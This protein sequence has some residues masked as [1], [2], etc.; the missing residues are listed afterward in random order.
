NSDLG[1]GKIGNIS[2]ETERYI[3]MLVENEGL[4]FD[5]TKNKTSVFS[6]L[7]S[8][9]EGITSENQND[10]NGKDIAEYHCQYEYEKMEEVTQQIEDGR[11]TKPCYL[12]AILPSSFN[13]PH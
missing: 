3:Y 13:A 11:M 8:L 1:D 4:Y 5:K 12:Q 10:I 9:S 7:N 6:R 2:R